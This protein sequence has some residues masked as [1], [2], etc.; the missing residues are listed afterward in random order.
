[1][2]KLNIKKIV[3]EYVS[4]KTKEMH[5]KIELAAKKEYDRS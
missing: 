1:M 2:K 4:K 5:I 3:K